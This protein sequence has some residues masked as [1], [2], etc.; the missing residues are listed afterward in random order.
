MATGT[1]ICDF[2]WKAVD[3]TLPATDGQSYS[4]LECAGPNGLLVAF[5][6]NHCPYVK[7]IIGRLVRD[8]SE[9]KPLGIGTVAI[10][11]NDATAYPEDSFDHMKAFAQAHAFALSLSARRGA[12]GRTGLWSR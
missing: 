5:I 6:C 9:L 8:A 2:G 3:F 12:G 7:A 10:C 1:P 4:I 11:S